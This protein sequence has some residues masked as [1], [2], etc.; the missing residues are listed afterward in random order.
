MRRLSR[1]TVLK[2][3]GIAGAAGLVGSNAMAAT[4][5]DDARTDWPVSRGT[6]ARTGYTQ[7]SG[8]GPY[9]GPGWSPGD[10]LNDPTEVTVVDGTA[11]IGTVGSFDFDVSTGQV[12]AYD[13]TGDGVRWIREGDS[14]GAVQAAPSVADG[15]VFVVTRPATIYTAGGRQG[16]PRQTAASWP[17]TQTAARRCGRTSRY[18]R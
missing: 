1:R 7:G 2:G 3:I 17:S 11:Y 4:P 18:S 10:E 5:D 12:A 6:N 8:P 9:A 16:R 14:F 15:R 13:A